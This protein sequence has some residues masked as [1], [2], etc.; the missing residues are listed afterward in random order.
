MLYEVIT[1]KDPENYTFTKGVGC[2]NCNGTGMKGRTA[3]HEVLMID[4]HLRDMI[5][6]KSSVDSMRDYAVSKGLSTLQDE[7]IRLLK[8]GRVTIDEV[9]RVAYSGE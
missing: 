2:P 1:I 6:N 9:Y 5:S 4:R 3:V 7:C 8:E